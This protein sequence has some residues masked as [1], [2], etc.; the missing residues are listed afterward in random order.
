M[1]Y[2]EFRKSY[3]DIEVVIPPV[4]FSSLTSDEA[5]S[6]AKRL[7]AYVQGFVCLHLTEAPAEGKQQAA[8]LIRAMLIANNGCECG[9]GHLGVLI[10][11][12]NGLDDSYFRM[13]QED[14]ILVRKD[15][16]HHMAA[17]IER[18]FSLGE[19]LI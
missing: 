17:E 13:Y 8:K 3:N 7:R 10:R 5:V 4:D 14:G 6:T 12:A 15:W 19:T 11:N 2:T 1:P 18:E 9:E 16:C